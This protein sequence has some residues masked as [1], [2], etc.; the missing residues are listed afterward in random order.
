[1]AKAIVV[2]LVALLLG[3]VLSFSCFF[4]GQGIIAGSAAPTASLAHA[5][6]LRAVILSGAFL[7]LL[8]LFALGIG[9]II[10]HTA[11]AIASYVG[12]TL[13]LI[14]VLQP[15]PGNLAR[16]APE[17]LL[18]NSVSSSVAQTGDPSATW[19]FLLMG[20]YA[21]V[22]LAIGAALLARRDA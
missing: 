19:A 4:L 15:L 22:T 18:A 17:N 16:F 3:E 13:L 6:V 9:F 2:A 7:A 14:I 20:A 11:G 12:F 8:A 1:M 10:R 21:A 5:D